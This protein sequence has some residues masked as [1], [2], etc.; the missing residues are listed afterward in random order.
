MPGDKAPEAIRREQILSAAYEVAAER[1][2]ADTTILQVALA[3]GLSPALVIYHFKTRRQLLLALLERLL[4][5]T[6][7]LTVDSVATDKLAPV[8]RLITVLRR[9]MDRL[10]GEPLRIRLTFDYWIAG[11]RDEEVRDKLSA[12]FARYREAF[13]PLAAAVLRD[14]PDRFAGVTADALAG[15]SVSL[16]K[17]CAVQSMIDPEHFDIDKHLGAAAALIGQVRPSAASRTS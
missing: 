2:L 4:L 11:V 5:T 8:D 7:V 14:D 1:G 3:A 9:E 16:I 10:S 13:R 6:T 15:L 17:G 12:E